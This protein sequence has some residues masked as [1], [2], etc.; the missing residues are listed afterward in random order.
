MENR[1]NRGIGFQSD[2][3]MYV[4][5]FHRVLVSWLTAN[6]QI[7]FPSLQM[8]E[9]AFSLVGASLS[10]LEQ[11]PTINSDVLPIQILIGSR[12]KYRA[13]HIPIIARPLSR[14]V[15][16]FVLGYLTLLI[17]LA[18]SS[19]HLA[20]EHTRRDGVDPNLDAVVRHFGSEHLG[21]VHRGA[22]AGIVIEMA[23]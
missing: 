8:R 21:Q 23:L 2:E 4:F 14:Q 1:K 18:I 6:M 20:R 17:V 19:R 13:C 10:E 16:V 7:L 11:I 3:C 5:H 9:H 15:A 12:E 22:L